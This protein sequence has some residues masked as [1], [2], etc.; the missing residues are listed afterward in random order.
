[1]TEPFAA[2]GEGADRLDELLHEWR[3]P[4]GNVTG[5]TLLHRQLSEKRVDLIR[6]L[7]PQ[8]KNDNRAA[9]PGSGRRARLCH[10]AG[11]RA[12]PRDDNRPHRG[13]IA[14]S[15]PRA[16]ARTSSLPMAALPSWWCRTRCSGTTDRRWSPSSTPRICLRSIRNENMPT[17]AG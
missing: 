11:D 2:D 13:G 1:M 14:R 3:R 9:E 4:G 10:H 6:T 15:L 8:A 16:P 17:L 7:L 5:F 12:H